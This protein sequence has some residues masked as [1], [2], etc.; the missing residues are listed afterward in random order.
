M[1]IP[2]NIPQYLED[3]KPETQKEISEMVEA[4]KNW[5]KASTFINQ[6]REESGGTLDPWLLLQMM[7]VEIDSGR[8]REGILL[9]LLSRYRSASKEEML[10]EMHHF[11]ATN[12]VIHTL[13]RT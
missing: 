12:P 9:R 11:I 7:W 6:R 1:P 5:V 10:E 2:K 8:P 13:S 4:L 3:A